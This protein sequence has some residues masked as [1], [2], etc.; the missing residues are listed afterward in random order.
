M[1][2]VIGPKNPRDKSAINVTSLSRDWSQQLSPMLLGPVLIP[3]R[4]AA[5]N[6]ENAWQ[7][8]KVYESH[9]DKNGDPSVAW[10]LWSEKG[11]LTP[12]GI[13]Y[14]MGRGAKP[15]YSYWNG[16][17]MDYITAR[18]QIYIPIYADAAR[19]TKEYAYLEQLYKTQGKI[20]LWDVDGYDYIGEGKKLKDLPDDP[21]KVLGHGMVLAMMLEGLA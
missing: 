20:T 10:K 9:L 15:C 19:A 17:K 8:S 11:Y 4:V 3:G 7:F 12:R 21:N 2:R 14:P 16:Q 13:R 6:V 1:V 5:K 18:K